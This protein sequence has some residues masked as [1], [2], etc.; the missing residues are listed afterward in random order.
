MEHNIKGNKPVNPLSTTHAIWRPTAEFS[1]TV[2]QTNCCVWSLALFSQPKN[3]FCAD[4][5]RVIYILIN[6]R[7]LKRVDLAFTDSTGPV[8]PYEGTTC[9]EM[10]TFSFVTSIAVFTLE[11]EKLVKTGFLPDEFLANVNSWRLSTS[12]QLSRLY[13]R[14]KRRVI[15]KEFSVKNTSRPDVTEGRETRLRQD[16]V[17]SVKKAIQ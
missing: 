6:W 1:Q 16:S 17:F 7:G 13:R 15:L 8:Y 10:F 11:D 9:T 2:S 3:L 14:V 4:N 5:E 12:A